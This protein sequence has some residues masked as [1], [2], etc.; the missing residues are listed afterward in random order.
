MKTFLIGIFTILSISFSHSQNKEQT[1]IL[2]KF[3]EAHN[4]GSQDAIST[5]IKDTYHPEV[6]AKINLKD[7][8]AFYNQIVK[9]FG[10][11]NFM[12]YK[13]IEE[14]PL[15]FVVQLI[16]KE[17]YIKNQYI[18]PLEILVVKIDLS[19]KNLTYM[20]RGLRIGLS[21]L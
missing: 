8:V 11:L 1:N 19:K 6:Y 5:F 3:I 13:K 18:N 12:I 10:P 14:T 16:K 7:H 9:E 2:D 20:E 21:C 15:R 4:I 17:E